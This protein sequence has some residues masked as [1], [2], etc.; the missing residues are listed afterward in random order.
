MSDRIFGAIGLVLA[1]FY[2]WAAMQIQES[3]LSDVVGP[4]V[5]PLV[6]AGVLGL[7]SV[8]FLLRPDPE[9]DWPA[10]GPL[11]EIGF[12]V[13]VM[14][15]YA[16]ALP[17]LG[18]VPATALASGY[19]TWRLGTPLLQSAGIGLATAGGIWAVFHLGLGL[20]LARGPLGI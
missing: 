17:E 7:A 15:A 6:I 19:L 2:A 10:W 20:S 11:A 1:L 5:F 13:L 18:F 16:Q 3:F 14:I 8:W 4:R 9:P 12:A